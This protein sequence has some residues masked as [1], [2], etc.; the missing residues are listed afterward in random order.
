MT[1][2]L[3]ANMKSILTSLSLA[4]LF[5]F[6]LLSCGDLKGK[7][8]EVLNPADFNVVKIAN[9]YQLSVP[10][11]MTEAKSLNDV[12][13]LQY[14]NVFKETYVIVIDEDKQ[15][16][17]DTFFELGEYDTL[18]SVSKNYCN[19]QMK[20]LQ[21]NMTVVSQT[22]PSAVKIGTLD[23]HQV[24]MVGTSGDVKQEIAYFLTFIEGEEKVYMIMSWTLKNRKDKYSKTF[25]EVSNSF[26]L[27]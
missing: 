14:Q 18:M 6:S 12:A 21:E 13:S 10:T 22:T 19:I 20:M 7:K 3:K 24:E 8:E 26:K 9:E 25:A 1:K 4:S 11:Y 15:N 16:L 17:I 27:L 5:V 2:F 23:A